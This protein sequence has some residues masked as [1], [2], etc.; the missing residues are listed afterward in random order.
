M[1]RIWEPGTFAREAEDKVEALRSDFQGAWEF[2]Q[3]VRRGLARAAA[4]AA[5]ALWRLS[6][7]LG[8]EA[9]NGRG[10]AG[11]PDA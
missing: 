4:G 1:F 8:K 10:L 9:G 5:Y 2:R 3:A 6:E 11:A 7:R